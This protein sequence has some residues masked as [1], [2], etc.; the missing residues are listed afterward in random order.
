VLFLA[1]ASVIIWYGYRV[2]SRPAKAIEQLAAPISGLSG[3]LESPLP[4]A[5][6][7][8]GF[9]VTHL[10]QWVGEQVPAD[11]LTA[12]FTRRQ[13]MAAGYRSDAALPIFLGLRL[14]ATIAAGLAA[15]LAIR[16]THLHPLIE[17]G[18][19]A[20][21]ALL[22]HM[23]SNFA[24]DLLVDRYKDI[25]RA[26]LPDALDL[27]IVAVEAGLALDQALRKVGEEL[28]HTHPEISKEFS[29]VSLETRTGVKRA[30]ALRN[31]AERTMEPEIRK[32]VAIM[33]QTDKFGTSIADSLRAHS[34]FMRVRRRQI[35]EEKANKLGVKLTL[36]VFFFILPAILIIAGGP[37]FL[38]IFKE[39]LP[40]LRSMGGQ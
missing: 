27:L 21:A 14:I 10:L 9:R 11:P 16:L 36:V 38:R 37:A 22:G 31:L 3:A 17:L 1:L 24:L 40:A 34:E 4:Q 8:H 39:L 30:D 28:A 2:Y 19:V 35:A 23:L 6:D 12:S 5:S 13:L 20:V 33:V 7:V 25:L 26:S 29:L 15:L 32:F 18:L